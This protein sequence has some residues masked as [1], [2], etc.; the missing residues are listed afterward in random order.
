MHRD[1]KPENLIFKKNGDLSSLRLIDFGFAKFIEDKE[2]VLENCGSPGFIAPEIFAE[3]GYDEKCDVFSAGVILYSLLTQESPFSGL[4]TDSILDNNEFC[5]VDYHS[6]NIILSSF[7]CQELLQ[8]MLE[9]LPSDRLT[10][11]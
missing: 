5:C 11:A 1:I 8:N 2:T 10:I 9:K 4:T 3:N 7:D 6:E